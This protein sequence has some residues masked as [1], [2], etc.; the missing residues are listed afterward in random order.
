MLMN[1][2]F[3]DNSLAAGLFGYVMGVLTLLGGQ[4]IMGNCNGSNPSN[5][6]NFP[7][8]SLYS[9][10]PVDDSF[11]GLD[12]NDGGDVI[13]TKSGNCFHCDYECPSLNRVRAIRWVNR[14][15]AEERG[16]KPCSR[17]CPY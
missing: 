12:Q 8:S 16:M 10:N 6:V 4:A 11:H 13:I 14:E 3:K 7:V 17:C 9:P 1:N 5:G 15:D 2:P